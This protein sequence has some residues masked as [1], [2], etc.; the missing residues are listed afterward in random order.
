MKFSIICSYS[1]SF[2]S[3]IELIESCRSPFWQI[4]I[5]SRCHDGETHSWLDI[6]VHVLRILARIVDLLYIWLLKIGDV[7]FHSFTKIRWRT[8]RKDSF[9]KV[10]DIFWVTCP[11]RVVPS[12][13]WE[14]R[15]VLK[16]EYASYSSRTTVSQEPLYHIILIM[17]IDAQ[18]EPKSCLPWTPMMAW[19]QSRMKWKGA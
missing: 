16:W 14:N 15:V 10:K 17:D 19:W 12:I 11:L 1:R 18:L 9:W 4:S 13:F 6:C 2:Y 3:V 8:G 7:A 5:L